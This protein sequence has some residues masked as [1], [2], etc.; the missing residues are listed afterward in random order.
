MLV[1]R[2]IVPAAPFVRARMRDARARERSGR[3]A[4]WRK[5]ESRWAGV[6]L[7]GR[8]ARIVDDLAQAIDPLLDLFGQ[9]RPEADDQRP[10]LEQRGR[11]RR[12]AARGEGIDAD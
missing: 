4:R 10:T 12:R 5:R 9:Q 8:G 1:T 6:W 7:R 11:E 2:A 3:A